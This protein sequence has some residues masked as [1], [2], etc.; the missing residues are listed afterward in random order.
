M[1]LTGF[2][3][4]KQVITHHGV[5]VGVYDVR[6]NSKR[7]YFLSFY[8]NI[9]KIIQLNNFNITRVVQMKAAK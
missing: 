8:S 6:L 9:F 1:R 2:V 5:V 3:E 7:K 4:T